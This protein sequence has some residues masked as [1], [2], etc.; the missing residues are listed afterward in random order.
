MDPLKKDIASNFMANIA[1]EAANQ[2]PG[3][4]FRTLMFIPLIPLVGSV[5]VYLFTNRDKSAHY[6]SGWI[7]SVFSFI[8]F[9]FSCLLFSELNSSKAHSF[10]VDVWQWFSVLDLDVSFKFRLDRLSSVMCL[11]ITGIG[12]LIHVYAIGYMHEDENK[13]RF[14]AYLNLF[15]FSMLTLVLGD[16]LLLMF[17]G[18]EGVG[19]CSYLLIGFWFKDMNNS[20]AGQK[21]FV[22]N[23]IGD[24]GFL[25]GIFTLF[26]ATGQISF[27]GIEGAF[28]QISPRVVEI[29]AILLFIGAVG[30]SAQIPLYV[31]LPDAM[32]GPT[33]VSALIH[34]ATM[35]TAG[36]YMITRLSFLYVL[37]PNTLA[38]I[39][40][41]GTLTAFVAASIALVQND[42]KKVLAYSTVSQLGYMFMALGVAAFSN[43]MFHV[44]TH[45]FFKACLFMGAGSVIIGCH[46]E[47]DMREFGGLM[48]KMPLTGLT[49]LAATLAIA[50]IP[51]TS[52]F[53]SKDGILWTVFSHDTFLFGLKINTFC[54]AVGLV[55]A[56]MTAFYMGR[57]F[58]LTFLGKYR[59]HSHPHESPM[60]V[61][62]PLIILAI[63]S[64]TYGK[65][66]GEK[67]IHYLGQWTRKDMLVGHE[68]LA[69]NHTYHNLEILS[70]VVAILGISFAFVVFKV[71]TK[72]FEISL[73]KTMIIKRLKLA[74]DNKWWIDEIYNAVIVSPL[75]FISK[76]LFH[77]LD[78][79]IIDGTVNGV[80]AFAQVTA[81][82]FVKP[83]NGKISNYAML[84]FIASI[85]IC[86]FGIL[87]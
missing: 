61:T 54:W 23:R 47:Q 81:E 13:P 57:S 60:V 20:K 51:F 2:D 33:P 29:A 39:L 76:A 79:F 30:K 53:Y 68:V 36:I 38:V 70:S 83:Q 52:G 87:I 15:L 19:L 17:V 82:S 73:F 26:F 85:V 71:W 8:A 46:H 32:A 78:R 27:L 14:F 59:G 41:I 12:T 84:M 22:V 50:G 7:A 67:F 34:A 80:G 66:Y 11:I 49:Y 5:V 37:A 65:I 35:V 74:L 3:M 45:A 21:A 24:A 72:F 6:L 62:F 69:H 18:W 4:V 10:Y 43:G 56:F 48:K 58:V 86:V 64:L 77:V 42:I 63:P 55:T 75:L 1:A 31:W 25:L 16:N 9:C 40:L 28:N 44:V